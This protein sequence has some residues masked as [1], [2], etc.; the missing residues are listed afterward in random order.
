MANDS[1]SWKAWRELKETGI[2]RR[3][4]DAERY[5]AKAFELAGDGD[6]E[7]AAR[8]FGY[9]MFQAERVFVARKGFKL[10]VK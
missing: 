5:L 10:E 2:A 7:A 8:F 6:H 1:P 3:K 9:A 4:L